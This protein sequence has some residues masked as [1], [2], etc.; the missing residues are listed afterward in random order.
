MRPLYVAG[1]ERNV[2]K[3]T[4]CIGLIS[5]FQQ[6]GLSVGYTKPLG[7]R[8][9]TMDGQQVHDDARVVTRALAMEAESVSMAVPLPRGRVEKEI[10]DLHTPE[11]AE[12]VA[13]VC[14][15][16]RAE[17]DVIVVESM[18]HVAMGS[19]LKLSAAEVIRLLDARALLISG[20]GIG[21]AIDDISLCASF[22]T[23]RGA[24][25][26]G[27]VVNKVWPEK[28]R[29]IREA[30]T[31]GLENLGIRSFG[32]VPYEEMLSSPTFSQVAEE[33]RGE[34]L[35]GRESLTNRVG[36]T[37]VAAMEPEHM[38][39]YLNDRVMVITPGDRSDNIL[40]ILSIYVLG[41]GPNPP[42]TGIILTGGFRPGDKVMS[43]MADS[44]LP[45][46]LC[47]EDT[48]T[49]AARLREMVFKITPEDKVRIEA[50]KC[51]VSE[52]VDIDAILDGLRE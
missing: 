1:T 51:L 30:T 40:A 44:G 49:V 24:D 37:I 23:C 34:I 2:G 41:K 32:T 26:M 14:R 29:R 16:L 52:Y 33:L 28:Y 48:Y 21:R 20:G 31:K 50:A 46:M 43:M 25:L 3:T 19:C 9:T 47:Q 6:K 4:F 5:A 15:Q 11:L 42:V 7:Q 18:G 17:H 38:V 36:S 27:A 12:K 39:S 13:A 35:C 10:Y 8:V 45:A 22:L